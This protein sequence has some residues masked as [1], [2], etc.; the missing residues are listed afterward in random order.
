MAVGDDSPDTNVLR[1]GVAAGTADPLRVRDPLRE[2]LGVREPLRDTL[3][4]P[5]ADGGAR[6]ADRDSDAGREAA[7]LR[8]TVREPELLADRDR[9][10]L[11]ERD[12]G[13][14][15]RDGGGERDPDRDRLR[16][17]DALGGLRVEGGVGG[18]RRWREGCTHRAQGR[19]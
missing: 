5:D 6:L 17:R 9:D 15:E 3:R 11:V 19:H 7:A 12:A 2:P 18:G 8:D 4:D 1:T 10:G 16:E 13:D 14:D